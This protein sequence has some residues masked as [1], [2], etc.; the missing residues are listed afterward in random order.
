MTFA[1][2]VS[3]LLA[4]LIIST[5]CMD[6]ATRPSLSKSRPPADYDAIAAI[7]NVEHAA[8]TKDSIGKRINV[9]VVVR[10]VREI[11]A[12]T[13]SPSGS[14]QKYLLI[15]GSSWDPK[16]RRISKLLYVVV[17]RHSKTERLLSRHLLEILGG[18]ILAA[19]GAYKRDQ[20]QDLVRNI[21]RVESI[22]NDLLILVSDAEK[23][24]NVVGRCKGDYYCM[25]GLE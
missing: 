15:E 16:Q 13:I 2:K 10:K 21:D 24:L 3:A 7:E 5:G 22:G 6:S 23:G 19:N 4:M 8:K 1:K 12:E 17:A 20:W 11:E 14:T 18:Q 9:L 25:N